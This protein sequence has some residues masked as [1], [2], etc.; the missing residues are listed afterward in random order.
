M[1]NLTYSTGFISRQGNS[2]DVERNN[3]EQKK[4]KPFKDHVT[5]PLQ[6]FRYYPMYILVCST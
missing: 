3:L 1:L 2:P 6:H 4:Q 5:F